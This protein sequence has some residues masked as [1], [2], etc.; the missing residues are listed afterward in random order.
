LSDDIAGRRQRIDALDEALVRLLNERADHARAIGTL[1]GDAPAYSP[2]REAAVLKHVASVS[3]GPLAPEHLAR[4]FSEVMSA[5]R[6]LE[7]PLT[8]SYL[9]PQGTFSEMALYKH[10]GR[11]VEALPC[12]SIDEVVRQAE[13]GAAQYAVVPVENS[14]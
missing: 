4:I 14:T 3:R 11:S 9:G 2:E 1:K 5:C 10:F 7:Q 12:T 8:I 6:S 13:S